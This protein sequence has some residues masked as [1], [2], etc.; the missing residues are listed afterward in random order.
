VKA[1]RRTVAEWGIWLLIVA[2]ILLSFRLLRF[3]AVLAKGAV[4][5][6][7]ILAVLIYLGLRTR[8]R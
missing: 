8:G 7:A 3:A 1:N 6:I 4:F 2:L 5:L